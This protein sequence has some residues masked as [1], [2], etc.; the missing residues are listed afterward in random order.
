[1]TA[2]KMPDNFRCGYIAIVGRPNVGKSTLMNVLI[3]AK[4]SIT[5]RKAQ[6]TRHRITGIQTVPDAQFIYVDT[7]G[8]QT[9]HSNALNKTLNKTVTNT[10][11]SS[12][13]ILYV[14]EAGTFG[15][16]DQQVMDLLPKEVPCILVINKSD[17]VKDKA[18][19]LPFA[20]KIAAMRDF[21]AIVPVSAKLHFQLEGL[22]DE[23]K[24]F[25]PENQPIFGP[26]DITDRSEKFLASEIVREKLFRFVGDELPYTSTVLIEK[27]EQEGDLRRVFAAILV[28]RDTHKSMI[29]GNKGAR[30]KEV[31]T[32]ARLDMEKLFGGPVYLEIWVKVKSGWADN[33]AGLRAYGYE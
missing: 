11:I 22:Q 29:I 10:L 9:R 18:V 28:E 33:E 25:L 2:T 31:S 13:V 3:G 5:S 14:I 21:A 15:P 8:F 16:A 32:Q 1:M 7:P 6:T 12:D 26:D 20:Q 24:R 23:I 19:L 30:L 4:V 17:R 27:F